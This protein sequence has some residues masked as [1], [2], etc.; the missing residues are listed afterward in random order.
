METLFLLKDPA[1]LARFDLLCHATEMM[2]LI[3]TE[4]T[5][6]NLEGIKLTVTAFCKPEV[7]ASNKCPWKTLRLTVRLLHSHGDK[8]HINLWITVDKTTKTT[9]VEYGAGNTFSY[10]KQTR[11]NEA[12]PRIANSI[13]AGLVQRQ[14][15]K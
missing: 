11:K 13:L 1:T 8:T 4:K 7:Q 12:F 10:K 5:L 2:S 3:D 6:N 9:T 14:S 15:L